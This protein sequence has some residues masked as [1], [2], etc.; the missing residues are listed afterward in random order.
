MTRY[1]LH[2]V[3]TL[4]SSWCISDKSHVPDAL[5]CHYLIRY[6]ECSVARS[7]MESCEM[8]STTESHIKT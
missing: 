1:V 7:V 6:C 5:L 3:L 2:A 4:L 8:D